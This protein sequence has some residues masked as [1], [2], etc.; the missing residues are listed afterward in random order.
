[1]ETPSVVNDK[2]S[3]RCGY[4]IQFIKHLQFLT[5]KNWAPGEDQTHVSHMLGECFNCL[6]VYT[7]ATDSQLAQTRVTEMFQMPHLRASTG[8]KCKWKH[9]LLL[10]KVFLQM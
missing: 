4:N 6:L 2:C 8:T 3:C 5:E 1:M 7:E 9:H 10:M